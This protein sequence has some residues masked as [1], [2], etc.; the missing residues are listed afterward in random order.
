MAEKCYNCQFM[1]GIF[2]YLYIF[3]GDMLMPKPKLA[4]A[5]R[6]FTIIELIAVICIIAILMALAIPSYIHMRDKAY[7]RDFDN[8]RRLLNVYA[9]EFVLDFPGQEVIW[10]PFANQE[11]NPE[12]VITDLNMHESWQVYCAKWPADKTRGGDATFTV[13]IDSKGNVTITPEEYGN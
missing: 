2:F 7:Q 11:P 12:T 6:G 10:S 4:K 3:I 5:N 13:E 9:T 1:R 8:S